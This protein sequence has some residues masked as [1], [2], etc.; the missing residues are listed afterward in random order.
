MRTLKN[1]LCTGMLILAGLGLGCNK[2]KTAEKV[3]AEPIAKEQ[4]YFDSFGKLPFGNSEVI[5]VKDFNGDGH[6]DILVKKSTFSGNEYFIYK[7]RM[8]Q[9]ETSYGGRK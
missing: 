9:S 2:E 3:P 7:N 6:L 4:F 5:E 1:M 8:P